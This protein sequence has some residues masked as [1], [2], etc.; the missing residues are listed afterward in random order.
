MYILDGIILFFLFCHV[1][2][3]LKFIFKNNRCVFCTIKNN[4]NI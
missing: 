1:I 3:S 2:Y 4:M